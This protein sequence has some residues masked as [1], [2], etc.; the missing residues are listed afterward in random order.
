MP[1][2]TQ[3]LRMMPFPKHHTIRR[4]GKGEPSASAVPWEFIMASSV[5]RPTVAMAP[6]TRPRRTVRRLMAVRFMVRFLAGVWG[7]GRRQATRSPK[8]SFGV[9]HQAERRAQGQLHEQAL[10][11]ITGPGELLAEV[12]D[13]GPFAL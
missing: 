1:P 2:G 3:R 6:P 11:R 7:V 12:D 5:G 9:A 13:G 4:T 8:C 10:Q